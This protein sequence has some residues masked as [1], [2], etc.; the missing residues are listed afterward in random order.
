[1]KGSGRSILKVVLIETPSGTL[2]WF[3]KILYSRFVTFNSRVKES[4]LYINH[5][6]LPFVGFNTFSHY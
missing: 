1:M 3:Y 4:S 2:Q 5:T 6:N